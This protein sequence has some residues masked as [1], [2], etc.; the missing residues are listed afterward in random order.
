[1]I[2]KGIFAFFGHKIPGVGFLGKGFS[3]CSESEFI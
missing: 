1:M 3:Y 2:I